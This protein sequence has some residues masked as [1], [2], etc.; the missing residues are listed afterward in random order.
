MRRRWTVDR[1]ERAGQESDLQVVEHVERV[2]PPPDRA[3]APFRR[4]LDPLQGHQRIDAA[5]PDRR[6]RRPG[7]AGLV[8]LGSEKAEEELRR[9]FVVDEAGVAPFGP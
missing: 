6:R 2:A 9:A 4:V 8:R 7:V 3:F 5:D 1:I